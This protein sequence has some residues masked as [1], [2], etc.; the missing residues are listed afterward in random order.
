MTERVYTPGQESTYHGG[1]LFLLSGQWHA[2]LER[3]D[4]A[5]GVLTDEQEAQYAAL[6]ELTDDSID[7]ACQAMR[8]LEAQAKFLD[9]EIARLA[10]RKVSLVKH[11]GRIKAALFVAV[12]RSGG[13]YKTPNNSLWINSGRATVDIKEGFKV[14]PEIARIREPELDRTKAA[15]ILNA[16]PSDADIEFLVATTGC[17]RDDASRTLV[18]LQEEK[19]AALGIYERPPVPF[20]ARR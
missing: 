16:T 3:I 20:L 2:L 11:V 17:D 1:K 14:A 4:D 12:Q 19:I 10:A 5:D 6:V 9:D 8:Q 15:L 13:K 18:A 7:V